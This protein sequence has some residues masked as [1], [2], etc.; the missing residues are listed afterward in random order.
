[1]I[2]FTSSLALAGFAIAAAGW[3]TGRAT[4]PERIAGALGG[5]ALMTPHYLWQVAGAGLLAVTIIVHVLRR[6]MTA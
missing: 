1:M 2:T 4:T 3:I 5:M 6:R